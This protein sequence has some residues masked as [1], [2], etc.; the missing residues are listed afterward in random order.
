MAALC[1][2]G[3]AKIFRYIEVTVHNILCCLVFVWNVTES[4]NLVT[5]A[6]FG[7]VLNLFVSCS[8]IAKQFL[9][10]A[11]GDQKSLASSKMQFVDATV[12]S[13]LFEHKGNL[14]AYLLVFYFLN[15]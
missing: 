3:L 13:E 12:K 8:I 14:T 15:P 5:I 7:C 11:S 4:E 1:E 9:L 2:N 10:S 6:R